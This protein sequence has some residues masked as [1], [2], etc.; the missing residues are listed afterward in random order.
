MNKYG[1]MDRQI[2]K[3]P[4]KLCDMSKRDK[5]RMLNKEKSKASSWA[6]RDAALLATIQWRGVKKEWDIQASVGDYKYWRK[7][8]LLPKNSQG[9]SYPY[10]GI[11]TKGQ[12]DGLKTY[13]IHKGKTAPPPLP[14][15]L[16]GG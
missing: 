3:I 2:K 8:N 11:P 16:K 10:P 13:K 14:W 1:D 12:E 6:Q 7:K 9:A 4:Q 15:E 5:C